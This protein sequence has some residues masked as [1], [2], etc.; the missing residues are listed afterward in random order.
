MNNVVQEPHT[1]QYQSASRTLKIAPVTTDYPAFLFLLYSNDNDIL[2][3]SSEIDNSLVNEAV[4]VC[5][6]GGG[7][8]LCHVCIL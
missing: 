5:V 6:G 2:F 8:V 3:L 4:F 7:G 1:H